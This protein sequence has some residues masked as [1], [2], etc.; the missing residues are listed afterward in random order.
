VENF[1]PAQTKGDGEMVN[2][3]LKTPALGLFDTDALHRGAELGDIALLSH[4]TVSDMQPG[5]RAR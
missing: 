3:L 5:R 4:Y 1:K 2:S